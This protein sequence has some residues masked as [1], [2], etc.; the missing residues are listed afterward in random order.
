MWQLNSIYTMQ[1]N[2]MWKRDMIRFFLR[3]SFEVDIFFSLNCEVGFP[4]GPI[5]GLI[6]VGENNNDSRYKDRHDIIITITSNTSWSLWSTATSLSSWSL[7][8][9]A[10][11][12]SSWYHHHH[13]HHHVT[14]VIIII[15]IFTLIRDDR[16]GGITMTVIPEIC[17]S[18]LMCVMNQK[19]GK[20]FHK[21]FPN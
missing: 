18:S 2:K 5:F 15:L 14:K 11:S 21:F 17:Q 3:V 19:Q 13:L 6:R 8:S 7:W 12:L 20:H 10:T 1:L 9:T 16:V 4:C